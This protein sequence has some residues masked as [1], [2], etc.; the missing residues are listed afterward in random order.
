MNS[1]KLFFLALIG[2]SFSSSFAFVFTNFN[3][4]NGLSNDNVYQVVQDKSGFMWVATS[5]GLNKLGPNGVKKYFKTDGL[6]SNNI[7]SLDT[8]ASG[9][10]WVGT[11]DGLCRIDQNKVVQVYPGS[12]IHRPIELLVEEDYVYWINQGGV[13][14]AL[15]RNTKEVTSFFNNRPGLNIPDGYVRSI[16]RIN[17]G[18]IAVASY[19]GLYKLKG[20]KIL[21]FEVKGLIDTSFY[22]VFQD[23][24]NHIWASTSGKIFKI[25]ND[26]VKKVVEMKAVPADRITQLYID[27]YEKLWYSGV[28]DKA[29]SAMLYNNISYNIN[30][31]LNNNSVVNNYLCDSNGDIWISTFGGG[32]FFIKNRPYQY[33][34]TNN[35][36]VSSYTTDVISGNRCLYIGTNT[37]FHY[38]DQVSGLIHQIHVN[39]DGGTEYIRN[40]DKFGK[41]FLVSFVSQALPAESYYIQKKPRSSDSIYFFNS[42]YVYGDEDRNLAIVDHYDNNLTIYKYEG[43]IFSLNHKLNMGSL[44]GKSC[45]VNKIVQIEN[46][47]YVCTI[48]GLFRCDT[49]FTRGETLLKD[50]IVSDIILYKGIILIAGELGV[51]IYNPRKSLG[52]RFMGFDNE[53]FHAVRFCVDSINRLWVSTDKGIFLFDKGKLSRLGPSDGLPSIHIT[54]FEYE[55][56]NNIMWLSSYNGIISIYLHQ[57][58]QY[59][60]KTP[61]FI[62]E[63]LVL[64]DTSY[65]YLSTFPNTLHTREIQ[66]KTAFFNYQSSPHFYL[67]YKMD[68]SK[69]Y[70]V[71]SNTLNISHIKHGTHTITIQASEFGYSWSEPIVYNFQI[72]P[73]WYERL[74]IRICIV[75]VFLLI[76]SAIIYGIVIKNNKK[77]DKRI[78]FEKKVIDLKLQALNA[79]INS[80]FVFN[81]LNAIQYF[82]SS[83]Q[84]LKASKFIADFAKF[85]RIIIDNSSLTIIPIEEEIRRI[86]LYLGLESMRFEDRLSYS[87]H[88]DS[89]I[90]QTK[91]MLPNMM[92]QPF[93]E[94][95]ILHGILTNNTKGFIEINIKDEVNTIFI[96]I[97]DNGIGIN[98]AKKKKKIFSR[99]SIGL[100]NVVQRLELFSGKKGFDYSIVDLSDKGETGTLVEIRLPK[101]SLSDIN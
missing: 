46:S 76:V 63:E 67:R 50:Q 55:K 72:S 30:E 92:I 57:L 27:P 75:L 89:T 1:R 70:Y 2:L 83:N 93:L 10:L 91:V 24:N 84:Q 68:N 85:M 82:V 87:I 5:Y 60:D 96:I 101:I 71:N 9:V 33:Y 49:S 95:S 86:H 25:E 79:A 88:V 54:N 98:T 4:L 100:T 14:F 23:F 7:L 37:C 73:Y 99:K 78:E 38:Y 35:G 59:V 31:V 16:S 74:W 81:V 69:W 19:N 18:F 48:K 97:K 39:P 77:A 22:K 13:L 64:D 15:N 94:N 26:E 11:A 32:L 12:L 66:I 45:F 61:K 40:I 20:D 90:N 52:Y 3:S 29:Y 53:S 44:L 42:R 56:N 34:N 80:H 36:L 6:Y 62:I 41:K 8:D 58:N 28:N 43:G 21:P 47:Y 51:Q 17:N 65:S